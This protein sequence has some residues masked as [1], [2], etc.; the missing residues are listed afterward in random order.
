MGLHWAAWN[1]HLDW[2]DDDKVRADPLMLLILR[3]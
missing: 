3:S 1:A 2:L